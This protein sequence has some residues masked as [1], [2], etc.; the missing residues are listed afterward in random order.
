MEPAQGLR[1]GSSPHE[2]RRRAKPSREQSRSR[3]RPSGEDR[4]DNEEGA[5]PNSTLPAGNRQAFG[6]GVDPRRSIAI[7]LRQTIRGVCNFW[8]ILYFA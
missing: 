6:R 2:L 8:A 1:A 7:A 5:I 3:S 4:L